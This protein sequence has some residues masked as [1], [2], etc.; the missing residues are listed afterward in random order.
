LLGEGELGLRLRQAGLALL[1]I[2]AFVITAFAL[3]D[4]LGLPSATTLRIATA[5]ACLIFIYNVGTH[6]F[7]GARWPRVALLVALLAD[8]AIFFTPLVDRPPSRGELMLFALPDLVI[9]LLAW[10]VSLL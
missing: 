1:G 10:L 2:A 7:P 9:F 5:A 8:V 4:Y 6:D 3:E